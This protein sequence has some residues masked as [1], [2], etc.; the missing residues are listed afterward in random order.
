MD[1]R[2][3]PM[4]GLPRHTHVF[5]YGTLLRGEANHRLLATATFVGA[6]HTPPQFRMV[7]L[8]AFPGILAGGRT[9]IAGEVYAVDA[10]T[11]AALDRLEG[12]PRFYRRTEIALEDGTRAH[13][14]VLPAEGYAGHPG[15]EVGD[16]RAHRADAGG[17][18]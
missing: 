11:L 3:N 4:T 15:I 17:E 12:H 13:A 18:G 2:T 7:S 16:W 10:Q 5:V 8:G 6:A 1:T 9:A 14:Y